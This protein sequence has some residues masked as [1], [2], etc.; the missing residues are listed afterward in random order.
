[1]ERFVETVIDGIATGSIYAALALALVLIYRSTGIVNFAQGELATFSTFIAWGLTQAG[2]AVGVAVLITLV[3]SLL[4][5]MAIERVV[6]RP[7]EG[8]SEL[9]LVVVTLG[10]FILLNGLMRWIWGPQNR[11]FPRLFP[12]E[13]ISIGGVRISVESLCIVGVL[14][15]VALAGD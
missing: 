8:R 14:L 2:L 11:G 9:A 5:G 6:I 15:V 4:G 10:M 13:T 1:M 3:L 7:V 12:D